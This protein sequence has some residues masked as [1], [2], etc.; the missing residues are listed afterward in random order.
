VS[1]HANI[2]DF[3]RTARSH[4]AQK[5]DNEQCVNNMV[6]DDKRVIVKEMLVKLG[7][8][9]TSVCRILKQLGV[10]KVSAKWVPRM[11]TDAHKET[12]KPVCSEFLVQ[13]ENGGD[14]FL[15]KI[16]TGVET[17]LHLFEPETVAQTGLTR[18]LPCWHTGPS[19]KVA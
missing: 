3:S 14:D 18:V 9:E 8:G 1:E 12:R 4:T 11:L 2:R 16:V 13:Y 15:A 19:S 5:P 17:W 6:S 7:I 10:E